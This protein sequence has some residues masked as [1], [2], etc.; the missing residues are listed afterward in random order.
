[1]SNTVTTGYRS[2]HAP[3]I[4]NSNP[5]RPQLRAEDTARVRLGT[6]LVVGIDCSMVVCPQCGRR[7]AG[8]ARFCVACGTALAGGAIAARAVRKVVTLLFVDLVESTAI[9]ERLDPEA[10]RRVLGRWHDAMRTVIERHGGTIEKFVGDAVMAVFGIPVAHED[11]ALRAVRAATEMR[12]ALAE[13]NAELSRALG[14]RIESRIG[15]NTGE[16]VAGSGET[17]VTG[18]AVNV[19]ARLEQA[20]RGGEILLGEETFRLVEG[21]AVVEPVGEL[22]V[23]GKSRPVRVYRLLA[24]L[25]EV[26]AF[27]RPTASPFV[28]RQ[29]EVAAL[30][31]A[32]DRA[33]ADRSCRLATVL[34]PPGIGKSRLLR[35]LVSSVR[36]RAHVV[37]GRCLPYGEG[38]T[39]WPLVDI[40]KLLGPGPPSSA[41]AELLRGADSG[42]RV[43]ELV[44]AAVGGSEA[45]A[46]TAETNWAV[47]RLL[48]ALARARPLIVVLEDLHWAEPAFLDLVEYITAFSAGSPIL[49]LGTARPE[50]LDI[51]PGW[52][53]PG[54]SAQVIVLEPLAG[55]DVEALLDGLPASG[56]LPH[57]ARARVLA[58]AEGHPLFVEQLVALH[59]QEGSPEEEALVPSTLR[60]LLV[61][62]IDR[63]G[64]GERDVLERAAV[65]GRTFHRGAVAELLP[66]GER[67]A[68]DGRLLSL[69]RQDFVRPD[70]SELPGDDG[71]RF[72]HVLIRDA[73]YDSMPKE[74]RAELHERYATWLGRVSGD[75][76]REYD[77]ILGYHLEQAHRFRGEL[78]AADE[79]LGELAGRA[80]EPLATAGHRALRREDYLAARNLLA[81]AA[82]LLPRGTELNLELVPS[83]GEALM[84][85]G[86]LREAEAVFDEGLED[87]VARGDERLEAL[88]RLGRAQAALLIDPVRRW[89]D[90]A[91]ERERALAL[92]ERTGDEW[93]MALTLSDIAEGH[94]DRRRLAAGI[95]SLRQALHHAEKAGDERLQAQ[96]RWR[97]LGVLA[98]GSTP[99]TDAMAYARAVEAWATE[100]QNHV[101][102][103]RA[104]LARSTLEAMRGRFDEARRL[105][106][107]GIG[108]LRELNPLQF[109][110]AAYF[111]FLVEMLAGSPEAAEETVRRGYESL[112]RMG[113]GA[114]R[115]GHAGLLA[116]ATYAQGRYDDARRYAETCRQ[117]AA[118]D[119]LSSQVLW[120]G[121]EAKVR[122]QRG[123]H[124]DAE[125]LAVEAVRTADRT[126]Y[127]FTRTGALLDLGEVRR[128]AGRPRPAAKAIGRA[129]TLFEQ[130]G[131]VVS[132]DRARAAL[133]ELGGAPGAARAAVSRR[134]R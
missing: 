110:A 72:V 34:G 116:H 63:L 81:R 128:A 39:Y 82:S 33:T 22:A 54:P 48:E 86:A 6:A 85:T 15:V 19:A 117:L 61:A 90:A 71:F 104:W 24:V 20:G 93:G 68:V 66:E 102:A 108:V 98:A 122:A 9:G 119:D 132:A 114:Y 36:D 95:A 40:V 120:R 5:T 4:A 26:P 23:K 121:A 2:C 29:Q 100:T 10:M 129:L 80:A 91:D 124:A 11:D 97:L 41:I 112:E 37:A 134:R 106:D 28:G 130:K 113:E 42:R 133:R 103:A 126:I 12:V 84:R 47:R 1:M 18:D 87:A 123:E 74:R 60:A 118:G 58:R 7:N 94:F 13:L 51:R 111:G 99:V 30:R 53:T 14:L 77:E 46:S 67:D 35:E 89:E 109:A 50:L 96:I 62:R 65:Q 16:V 101:A 32:F 92:L 25:P 52:A 69:V 75:R 115:S 8:D 17:Y 125:R 38:I 64:R 57:R 78:F 107:A 44:A 49:L 55:P 105:V 27:T 88:V 83:L 59:A 3:V 73:A 43:A 70:R 79:R 56:A 127:H 45:P 31:L 21:T 131:N 76:A